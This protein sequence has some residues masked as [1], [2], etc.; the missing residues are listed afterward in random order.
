MD[1]AEE[2]LWW[3]Q[4]LHARLLEALSLTQGRVLDAGCGTGGF[5]RKL[6]HQRP[7]L[8]LTG[9]DSDPLAVSRAR[10][11]SSAAI[12]IG[13]IDALPF[14]NAAFDAVI[15]ADV[16]CHQGV[17]PHVALLEMRR[18]LRPGGALILNMPAFM[19]LYSSHDRRVQNGLRVT[20]SQLTSL[21]QQ[22]GFTLSQVRYWNG[23]L[24]PLMIL[25]RRFLASCPDAPS[26]VAP[27]HPL[28]NAG[29]AQILRWE[30]RIRLPVGGSV[31]AVAICP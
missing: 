13:S 10:H 14:R 26:D 24:L 4:A 7:G 29:A 27:V 28:L 18:V 15:S 25:R 11:K 9:C 16:V 1:E 5:L 12:T 22:A 17:R 31:M 20:A 2:R 8:L 6:A 3:Y 23:F 21:L 30:Q 19:W